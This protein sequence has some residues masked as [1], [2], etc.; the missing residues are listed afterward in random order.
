MNDME[1]RRLI[2]WGRQESAKYPSTGDEPGLSRAG[3][4]VDEAVETVAP[5]VLHGR[6]RKIKKVHTNYGNG[7]RN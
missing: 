5:D 4:P 7:F 2:E 3:P 1:R 6:I